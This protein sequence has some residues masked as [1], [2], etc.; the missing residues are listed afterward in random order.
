MARSGAADVRLSWTSVGSANYNVWRST[1]AQFGAAA[2][3]GASGGA[4][5]LL[6]A[7]AQQ[8]PGMHYYLVRSV[9][10]CRWESP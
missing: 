7:G 8:L 6:D 3:V 2:F 4:T 1:D 5:T 9:N 10:S